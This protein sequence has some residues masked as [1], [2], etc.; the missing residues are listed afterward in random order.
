M[1]QQSQQNTLV[2]QPNVQSTVIHNTA[3]LGALLKAF[4]GHLL[5]RGLHVLRG[6]L[7][8]S[9]AAH[10]SRWRWSTSEQ[11]APQESSVLPQLLQGPS[12][13]PVPA[14]QLD[15]PAAQEP[16]ELPQLLRK[17]LVWSLPLSTQHL[18]DDVN[19]DDSP[20]IPVPQVEMPQIV[21]EQ[22]EQIP[23]PPHLD[24]Q[25]QSGNGSQSRAARTTSLVP[26]SGH[27]SGSNRPP[28]TPV[29]SGPSSAQPGPGLLLPAK[30]P[31]ETTRMATSITTSQ[32]KNPLSPSDPDIKASTAP[33]SRLNTAWMMSGV[34]I[35]HPLTPTLRTL[36]GM[37]RLRTPSPRNRA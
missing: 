6:H 15:E 26:S 13:L 8:Q 29:S 34:P 37:T 16:S 33:T 10:P 19:F 14:S 36:T 24:G 3:Q 20:S 27:A 2:Y 22:S 35:S 12:E 18:F 32:A 28:T 9:G 4:E 7:A 17:R 30:S 11:I 5:R 25:E 31:F 23:G 21:A 1:T